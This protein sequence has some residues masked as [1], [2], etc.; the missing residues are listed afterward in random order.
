MHIALVDLCC[1]RHD[2][3]GIFN[4]LKTFKTQSLKNGTTVLFI[5]FTFSI[6]K[7]ATL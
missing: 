3:K 4:K 7:C 5:S 1:M 6:F 2:V